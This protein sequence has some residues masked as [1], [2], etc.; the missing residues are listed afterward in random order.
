M[1]LIQSLLVDN[2]EL[3]LTVVLFILAAILNDKRLAWW[4]WFNETAF[5]AWDNA[6][7]KGLLEGLKGKEKLDHY[8]A[9]YRAE[10]IKKFGAPPTEGTIEQA[11][12]KAEELSTKEKVIRLSN[13][14]S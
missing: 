2:W 4:K 11:T 14:T 6:E 8:I 12:L 9:V 3:V 13:P 5:L 1:E 7:K 10:Y